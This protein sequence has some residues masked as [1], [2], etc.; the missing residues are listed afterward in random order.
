MTPRADAFAAKLPRFHQDWSW[1]QKAVHSRIRRE[2][3]LARR[4]P[5]E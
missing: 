3:I 2:E 1:R 4:R 5:E